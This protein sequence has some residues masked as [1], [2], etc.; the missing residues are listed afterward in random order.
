MGELICLKKNLYIGGIVPLDPFRNPVPSSATQAGVPRHVVW[1]SVGH[2]WSG[3]AVGWNEK[4]GKGKEGKGK[5]IS[6][7]ASILTTSQHQI[8]ILAW[9]VVR[10]CA[11]NLRSSPLRS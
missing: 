6:A 10:M 2:R 9:L 7:L 11:L 4:G 3:R 5:T 8:R 1:G